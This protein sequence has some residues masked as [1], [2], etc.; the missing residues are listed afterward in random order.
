MKPNDKIASTPQEPSGLGDWNASSLA[1]LRAI[2]LLK[3]RIYIREGLQKQI[4]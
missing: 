4:N 3:P 2:T 1:P